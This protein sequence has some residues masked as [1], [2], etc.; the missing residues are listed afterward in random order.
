MK[1]EIKKIVKK[2]AKIAGVTCI[3]AGAVAIVTS[4]TALQAIVKGG[5][6]L[7]DAIKKILNEGPKADAVA[8]EA[9]VVEED[10]TAEEAPAEENV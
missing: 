1:K 10:S 6:Y 3:A 7:K 5:E 4:K 8:T 9:P 2:T